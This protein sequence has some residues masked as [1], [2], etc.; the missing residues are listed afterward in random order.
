MEF[1]NSDKY[2]IGV[3]A[4]IVYTYFLRTNVP[5]LFRMSYHWFGPLGTLTCV[6]V[7]ILVSLIT[8]KPYLWLFYMI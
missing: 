2:V 7:G 3:N 4:Y 5:A 8:G 1:S 6:G